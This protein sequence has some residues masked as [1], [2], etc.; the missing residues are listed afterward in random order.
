MINQELIGFLFIF[1]VLLFKKQ[2]HL[3]LFYLNH[4][5]LCDMHIQFSGKRGI[6]YA[7]PFFVEMFQTSAFGQ[8]F[9]K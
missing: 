2:D 8:M 5:E 9:N 3:F 1:S 7:Y 4:K 6:E